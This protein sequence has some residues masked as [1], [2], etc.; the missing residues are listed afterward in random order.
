MNIIPVQTITTSLLKKKDHLKTPSEKDKSN[1]VRKVS[2]QGG[3]RPAQGGEMHVGKLHQR[4]QAKKIQ[5]KLIT[6]FEK[7]KVL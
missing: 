3:D 4:L 2:L 6:S 1:P 7:G 5:G